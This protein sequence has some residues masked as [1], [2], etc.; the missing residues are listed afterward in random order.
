[1]NKQ[2]S[3][4]LETDR[5]CRHAQSHKNGMWLPT[6]RQIENGHIRIFFLA[7]REGKKKKERLKR[8]KIYHVKLNQQYKKRH[9]RNSTEQRHEELK[10][11]KH[12]TIPNEVIL[13]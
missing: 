4:G 9:R 3:R 2:K 7:Y 5:L 1:M 12:F 11:Y 10:I 8:K 13:Q 6:G